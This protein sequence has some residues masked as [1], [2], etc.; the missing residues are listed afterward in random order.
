MEHVERESRFLQDFKFSADKISLTFSK[1][2]IVLTSTVIP[3][4]KVQFIDY[5]YEFR[6][7]DDYFILE[8]SDSDVII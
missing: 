3:G 2:R 4:E 7:K 1:I 8:F 6:K 5:R